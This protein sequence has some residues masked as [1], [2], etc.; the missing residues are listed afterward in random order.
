MLEQIERDIKTALLAGDK[1]KVETLKTVKSALQY[2]AVSK[3]VKPNELTDEQ[4]QVVLSRESKKR[5]EAANLYKNAGE[6][7][8]ADKEFIEKELIDTYL[9]EQLSEEEV[10]GVIKEEISKLDNPSVKDMGKI[11]GAVKVRTGGAAD[12]AVI[13]R[14]V[15]RNLES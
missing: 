14:L 6:Q 5:Q 10:E 12:G 7:E 13:A 9:P 1:T 15:K 3:S 8:R 11:I 2:E 4:V